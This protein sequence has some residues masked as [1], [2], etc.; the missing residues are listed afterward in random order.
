MTRANP[1]SCAMSS[2]GMKAAAKTMGPK[3]RREG[4]TR[5]KSGGFNRETLCFD[6]PFGRSADIRC[7][8]HVPR[9]KLLSAP[10]GCSCGCR[11]GASGGRGGARNG[12]SGR[13]GSERHG[14]GRRRGDPSSGAALRPNLWTGILLWPTAL[15]W[16]PA[17]GPGSLRGPR[18]SASLVLARQTRDAVAGGGGF[19]LDR[20]I[21]ILHEVRVFGGVFI[22]VA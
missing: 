18:S 6:D 4:A 7:E 1:I 9:A 10:T 2:S 13:C 21:A 15:L 8:W 20:S 17:S 14:E 5:D 22:E 12:P 3:Q 16:S 11:Y 19:G